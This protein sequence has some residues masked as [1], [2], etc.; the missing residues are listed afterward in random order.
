MQGLTDLSERDSNGLIYI[1]PKGF[2]ADQS[3]QPQVMPPAWGRF[4]CYT[5]GLGNQN[6]LMHNNQYDREIIRATGI[7]IK[8]QNRLF[9]YKYLYHVVHFCISNKNFLS[10]NFRSDLT[11][12][13]IVVFSTKM[14]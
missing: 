6:R 12:A 9:A 8:T 10:A 1:D 5:H 4:S 11:S 2:V 7:S 13:R 3:L 14:C